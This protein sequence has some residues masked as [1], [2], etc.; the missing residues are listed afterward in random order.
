MNNNNAIDLT[1]SND[2]Y[3]H[4]TCKGNFLKEIYLTSQTFL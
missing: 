4:K 2:R 3:A 1:N